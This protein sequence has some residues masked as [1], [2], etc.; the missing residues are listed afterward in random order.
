MSAATTEI[1][2]PS[3]A[4][5][6]INVPVAA[7]TIIYGGTLVAMNSSGYAVPASD[8]AGLKVIGRARATVDNSDGDAGDLSIEIDRGVFRYDNSETHALAITDIGANAYVED[9]CTVGH[10]GG[11]NDIVAGLVVDVDAD[12]VWIDTT[13]RAKFAATAVTLGNVDAEI[14]G[15]T[16][17]NPA[18]ITPQNTD[19]EIAALTFTALGATG[20][21]CE[22]LRDKCEDLAEDVIALDTALQTAATKA[23][24]ETLRGK[25][26][27]LADDVRAIKAALDAQGIT[28]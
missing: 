21:E 25:L 27:E 19:N 9:D 17:G 13:A 15:V 3:R 22:A 16:I 6:G 5:L 1:D 2:T 10:D 12:G 20:A 8:A 23:T 26:E 7:S 18:S 28:S 11:T 24:V 14:S 4:G